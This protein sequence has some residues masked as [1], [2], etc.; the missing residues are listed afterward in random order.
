MTTSPTVT[1]FTAAVREAFGYL[2]RE[3]GFREVDPPA[4]ELELNPF[5]VRFVSPTTVVQVEGINWGFAAQV[6][7][8]PDGGQEPLLPLWAVIRLRRPDLYEEV[9]K[10]PG[11]LGEIRAYAR[12][13]RETASDVLSGDF[14]VLAAA[15]AIVE[16]RGLQQR[17]SQAEETREH[18]QRAAVAHAA[19]AFRAGDFT[20]VVDLLMP[21]EKRL[22]TAQCAMLDYARTRIDRDRTAR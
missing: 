22:T 9:M 15:H 13:L 1:E 12:A 4:K 10:S 3:F 14:G 19:D 16:A 5:L 2:A 21:H 18:D 11:Q 20:R 8:G 17:L 6:I 7:V